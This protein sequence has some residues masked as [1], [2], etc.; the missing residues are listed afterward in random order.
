MMRQADEE[1]YALYVRWDDGKIEVA[2]LDRG[3]SDEYGPLD[4]IAIYTSPDGPVQREDLEKWGEEGVAETS[5]QKISHEDLIHVLQSLH[6]RSV[7]LDG[8][9]FARSVMVGTLKGALVL[10]IK[11]PHLSWPDDPKPE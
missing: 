9:K 8:K 2:R 7:F 1:Y 11:H 5:I 4:A 3:S 6:V 10:E